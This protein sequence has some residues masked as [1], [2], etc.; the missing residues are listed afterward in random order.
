MTTLRDHMMR[1]VRFPPGPSP[2][3]HGHRWAGLPWALHQ[4]CSDCGCWSTSP[5][6]KS[7]CP[8][9][10]DEVAAVIGIGRWA[11]QALPQSDAPQETRPEA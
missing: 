6:A 10:L 1:V 7:I 3:S 5:G 4:T 11:V 8:E 2:R 9:A